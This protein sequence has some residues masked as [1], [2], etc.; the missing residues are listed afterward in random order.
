MRVSLVTSVWK[1]ISDHEGCGGDMIAQGSDL[2]SMKFRMTKCEAGFLNCC[3][4]LRLSWSASLTI[5][6]F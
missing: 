1:D 5:V 4:R 2:V 6:V 3:D